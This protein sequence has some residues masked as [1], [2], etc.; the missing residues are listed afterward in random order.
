MEGRLERSIEAEAK[1][2]EKELEELRMGKLSFA[3]E[4]YKN[5]LRA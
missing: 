2:L 3:V 1:E 5:Q 4:E